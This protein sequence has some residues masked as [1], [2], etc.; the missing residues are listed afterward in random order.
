MRIKEKKEE[1]SIKLENQNYEEL[2][3][4]TRKVKRFKPFC[5]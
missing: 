5:G 4:K 3:L 1:E 2:D